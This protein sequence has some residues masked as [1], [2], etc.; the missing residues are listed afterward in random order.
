MTRRGVRGVGLALAS[1]AVVGFVVGRFG[2]RPHGSMAGSAAGVMLVAALLAGTVETRVARQGGDSLV[3]G[4]WVG[5][6]VRGTVGLVGAMLVAR[7]GFD[8]TD[9]Q[10]FCLWMLAAYL[11]VLSVETVRVVRESDRARLAKTRPDGGTE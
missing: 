10:A 5:V 7:F 3:L 2:D 8:P 4:Y 9:R 11:T 1:V 6:G